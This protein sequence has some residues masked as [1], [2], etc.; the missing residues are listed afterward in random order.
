MNLIPICIQRVKFEIPAEVLQEAFMPR[1]YNPSRREYSLDNQLGVSVDSIIRKEVVDARVSI[2][3]NLCSG[4]ETVIPLVGLVQERIDPYNFIYRIPKELTGGRS[5]TAVYSVSFNRGNVYGTT[6]LPTYGASPLLDVAN[7]IFQASA[8]IPAISSAYVTLI[9]DNTV[10][11][12]DAQAMGNEVYLRC[13]ISHEPN[14]ANVPPAY[15]DVFSELVVLATK[16]HISNKQIIALDEG[17]LRAG[18]NI[19]RFREIVDSYADANQMY[20]DH[21]RE[22]WR[23][24]SV[25]MDTT[26]YRRIQNVIIG[27]RH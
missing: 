27:G 12:S 3:V 17:Q 4:I 9:G 10:M 20:Q 21:M 26:K 6:Y 22:H 7:G 19:G 11:V 14:F 24:S 16:A 8:P 13:M 23:V 1:R 5:I 25:M 2:D 15:Y 18:V